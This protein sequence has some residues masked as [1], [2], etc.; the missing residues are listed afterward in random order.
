M[1]VTGVSTS[2]R[3]APLREPFVTALRMISEVEAVVVEVSTDDGPTGRGEAVATPAITGE[4]TGGI[5]AAVEGPL[6]Q[7]VVGRDLDDF[8][9]LLRAVAR[10]V[11]ANTSAKAAVD[12]ALHDLR[13]RSLGLPLYRLLG[14][15]AGTVATDVTISVGAPD[16]MAAAAVDRVADGFTTLKLKLAI[17]PAKDVDRVRAV[18]DAVG[19]GVRLRIDANQG[20]T[21]RQA[22]AIVSELERHEVGVELVEQPV[23]AHD[24]AGLAFVTERVATPVMADETVATPQDAL[25]VAERRAADLINVKLAKCGGLRPARQIAD[26][27]AAAGLGVLVGGMMATD[28]SVA[29]DAS[30]AATLPGVHDL[31]PAWWL[32][33]AGGLVRY[34]AGRVLLSDAAG[35]G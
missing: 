25:L 30:L 21:A 5:V 27:A 23:R 11:V 4:L 24:V 8:E 17:D 31:D 33:D 6:R 13:A 16:A 26:I 12:V 19:P 10:A 1:I 34:D 20:W 15:G 32:A 28:V 22:V 35:L 29:A 2:V 7:V 3:S 9:A 18:R 14:A